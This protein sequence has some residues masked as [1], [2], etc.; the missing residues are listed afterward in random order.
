M[1]SSADNSR[2]PEAGPMSRDAVVVLTVLVLTAFLMLVNETTL[3]VALPSIMADFAVTAATAQW[4]LTGVMLTMAII[5]PATGWILD[6]FTTRQVFLFSVIIF[7]LGTV[8]AALSPTFAVM[9]LGR[10]LQAVGTAVIIPLQMTVVMTVVP[11]HRRGTVMGIIGVVMAVGPALGPTIAGLILSVADWHMI[12]WAMVPLL[13]IAALVGV[14]KVRNIGESLST[15][16]DVL[17]L[18]LSAFAFGGLVYGLSSI[19]II[20]AGGPAAVIAIALTV[21][22]VL[23]LALFVW[24]Q[25]SL[26]RQ[27]RALLDLRP[28]GVHN[29]TVAVIA[30]LCL[31]A[32]LLGVVNTL[33][34]YLQ[35]ALL[36]TALVA[37]LVNLP[38]GLLETVVSPIGGAIFDRIGARPLAI[39]GAVIMTAALFWLATVD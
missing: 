32:A 4:L 37:G 18:V 16:L 11:P 26:G 39:P 14:W 20:I 30:L 2:L 29:Y 33:P 21:V 6:R 10:V 35:G 22:G 24:R 8:V 27:G 34:L 3:S 23:A 7:L 15:P 19:G 5:M 38:G 31:Q 13:L 36:T 9:L 25:L 28:L 1:S 17:S 12:F